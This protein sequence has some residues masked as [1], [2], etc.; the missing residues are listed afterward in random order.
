MDID[1]AVLAKVQ[2]RKWGHATTNSNWSSYF[3]RLQPST[4][5]SE[6]VN[7]ADCLSCDFDYKTRIFV[8]SSQ[9]TFQ[10]IE[11]TKTQETFTPLQR[12]IK[13]LLKKFIKSTQHVSSSNLSNMQYVSL[14]HTLFFSLS[15]S[16]HISY[17]LN[18]SSLTQQHRQSLMVR[19]RPTHSLRNGLCPRQ[20]LVQRKLPSTH[21]PLFTL[22]P[23]TLYF[24]PYSSFK[25]R[26]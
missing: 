15:L 5:N 1:L 12:L 9:N 26:S 10:N 7:F 24:T 22:L 4:I 3:R 20:R 18:H 21:T 25:Q 8:P 13:A 11:A 23:F 2:P 14:T 19:L 17:F 6:F 16:L